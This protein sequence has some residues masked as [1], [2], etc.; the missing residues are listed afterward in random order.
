MLKDGSILQ[1]LET[2][3]SGKARVEIHMFLRY[4]APGDVECARVSFEGKEPGLSWEGVTTVSYDDTG[5]LLCT[6]DRPG[7]YAAVS[8][9]PGPRSLA[10]LVPI[11]AGLIISLIAGFGLRGASR[12]VKRL[13]GKMRRWR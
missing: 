5:R 13:T 1:S 10:V 7:L 8:V 6:A 9:M 12:P 4:D 3:L 11:A 2:P